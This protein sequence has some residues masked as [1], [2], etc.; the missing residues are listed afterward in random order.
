M[1]KSIQLSGVHSQITDDEKK[2][3]RRKVGGLEKYVPKNA[4][5]SVA[6]EVKLKQKK[7]KDKQTYECEVILNLPKATLAAHEK[8]TTALAAIDLVEANLR[9]QLKKYKDKHGSSRFHRHIIARFKR[10]SLR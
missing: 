2:Y 6:A 9:N 3:V 1:I 8:A 10:K 7:A 4:R 5:Q